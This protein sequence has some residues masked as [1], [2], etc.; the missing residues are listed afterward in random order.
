MRKILTYK[1]NVFIINEP[2]ICE[3]NVNGKW[4]ELKYYIKW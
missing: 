1:S 3:W 2:S 4:G